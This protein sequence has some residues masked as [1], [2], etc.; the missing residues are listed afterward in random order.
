MDFNLNK[1][2]ELKTIKIHQAAL[3]DDIHISFKVA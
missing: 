1:S 3:V 2:S